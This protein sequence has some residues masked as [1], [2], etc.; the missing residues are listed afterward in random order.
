MARYLFDE[1][2]Q[3]VI[4]DSGSA[5]SPVNLFIPK[6]INRKIDPFLGVSIRYFLSK[7]RFSDII[8][9]ILIFIPLGI[10]LHGMLR[11]RYELT[12]KISLATLLAGTLF[13]LGVESMQYFS[14]TRHS[15]LIDVSTNMTGIAMGIVIDRVLNGKCDIIVNTMLTSDLMIHLRTE[16]GKVR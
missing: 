7:S 1:G 15:S 11:T 14:M 4:H 8:L 16:D 5:L 13:A 9:N 3:D 10:L 6:Y 12:L 2:K